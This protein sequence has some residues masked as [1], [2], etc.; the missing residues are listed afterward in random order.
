[1]LQSW[2]L[3]FKSDNTSN[4]EF[5][6]WVVLRNLPFE[7]HD[8]AL[9]ITG[10]LGEVIGINT[11]N[12]NATDLRICVYLTINKGWITNID[13]KSKKK[14][15]PPHKVQ[16]YYNKLPSRCKAYESWKP[17]KSNSKEL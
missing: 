12:K 17:K 14:F 6:T 10:T 15:L 7:H 13:L 16:V 4:L 2:I 5:P 8:Q 1:M 3:G 9:A 11:S